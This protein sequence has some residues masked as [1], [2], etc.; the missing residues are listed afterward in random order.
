[1]S[2]SGMM[3][4]STSTSQDEEEQGGGDGGDGGGGGEEGESPSDLPA[5]GQSNE[6]ASRES[7]RA[8]FSVHI[9]SG[10]I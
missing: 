9:T 7:N 6:Q 1:M 2:V 8:A 5:A 3:G 10:K 4:S